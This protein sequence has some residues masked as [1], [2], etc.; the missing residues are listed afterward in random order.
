[1][2]GVVSCAGFVA[3]FRAKTLWSESSLSVQGLSGEGIELFDGTE[4]YSPG[5]SR[6]LPVAGAAGRPGWVSL[7]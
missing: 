2:H 4:A 1:V 5:A 3:N 6:G 7:R